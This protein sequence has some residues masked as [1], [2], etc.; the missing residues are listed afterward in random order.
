ML[1]QRREAR[2]GRKG[3]AAMTENEIGKYVVDTAVKIHREKGPGL[4]ETVYEVILAYRL[5]EQDIQVERQVAIPIKYKYFKFDE[6]FRID[7]MLE[8]KVIV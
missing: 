1:S 3:I 5:R 8:N 4:L 6:G 2:Q 7:L